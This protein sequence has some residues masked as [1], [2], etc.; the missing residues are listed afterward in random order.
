MFKVVKIKL[1]IGERHCIQHTD[2]KYYKYG[3]WSLTI[4]ESI[5]AH[6]QSEWDKPKLRQEHRR[7]KLLRSMFIEDPKDITVNY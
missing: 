1:P 6:L 3:Y 7:K 4:A 5:K 2:G